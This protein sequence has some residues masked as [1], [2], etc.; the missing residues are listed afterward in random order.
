MWNIIEHGQPSFFLDDRLPTM[1]QSLYL[2]IKCT[3]RSI[4]ELA[5]SLSKPKINVI[6]SLGS[7]GGDIYIYMAPSWARSQSFGVKYDV[8]PYFFSEPG[9]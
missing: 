9:T 7:F 4:V 5:S 8:L 1:G 6:E 2:F 3:G